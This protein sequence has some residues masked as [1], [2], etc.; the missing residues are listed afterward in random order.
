MA[1]GLPPTRDD[2]EL[3]QRAPGDDGALAQLF[4]RH[5]HYVYRL[6][7]GLLAED[8]AADDVVQEVFLKLRSGRITARPRAR[9]TTWLY[10]VA[11]NTAREQA[12]KRRR[13]W[14]AGAAVDALAGVPDGAADPALSDALRDLGRS[15]AALPARQREVVL[16][17]FYEG[18]DT[19]ETAKILG[20]RQGTV[21]AHLHRATMRLRD[22]LDDPQT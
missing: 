4:E 20:C 9:F 10:R 3:L 16:L 13:F 8:H 11:I 18:F 17:R 21:K 14:G 1:D 2:W 19:A 15:L 12:R 6:A 7:W 22:V 5:R